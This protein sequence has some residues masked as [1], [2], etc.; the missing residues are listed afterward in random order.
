MT[1]FQ[2]MFS[3]HLCVVLAFVKRVCV[4]EGWT[5]VTTDEAG[6]GS[7]EA[8][9]QFSACQWNDEFSATLF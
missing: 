8:V 4:G 1:G 5:V 6:G 2:K 3:V 7:S 9:V